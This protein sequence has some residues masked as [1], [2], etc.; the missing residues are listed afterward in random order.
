[1]SLTD[2]LAEDIGRL[3]VNLLTSEEVAVVEMVAVVWVSLVEGGALVCLLGCRGA[4]EEDDKE[5][6]GTVSGGLLRRAGDVGREVTSL[7][8]PSGEGADTSKVLSGVL[9]ASSISSCAR[10][11]DR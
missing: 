4:L 3:K 11:M 1:M 8:P 5:G 7:G 10:E 2:S 6:G 9:R